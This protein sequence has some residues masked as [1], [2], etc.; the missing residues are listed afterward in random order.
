MGGVKAPGIERKE[1]TPVVVDGR[2][3]GFWDTEKGRYTGSS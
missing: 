1:D 3:Q 2:G